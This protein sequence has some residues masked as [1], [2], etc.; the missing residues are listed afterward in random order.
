MKIDIYNTEKNTTLFMRTRPGVT[1]MYIPGIK[2]V[3]E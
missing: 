1:E 3:G 2:W